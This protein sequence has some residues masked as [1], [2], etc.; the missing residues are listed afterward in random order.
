MAYDN[1]AERVR[2]N[3]WLAGYYGAKAAQQYQA[4]IATQRW[5]HPAGWVYIK[6]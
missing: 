4:G 6:S 5:L 1:K 2:F 3:Y